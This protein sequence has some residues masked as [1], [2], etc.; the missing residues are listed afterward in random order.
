[1]FHMILINTNQ[2]SWALNNEQI[3][4]PYITEHKNWSDHLV[5]LMHEPSNE[6]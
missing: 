2:I 6:Q 5:Y 1:M 4:A 3:T